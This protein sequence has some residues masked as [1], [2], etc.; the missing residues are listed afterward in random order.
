[1]AVLLLCA[2]DPLANQTPRMAFQTCPDVAVPKEP[3]VVLLKLS[4]IALSTLEASI[5]SIGIN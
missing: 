4:M 3:D 1:V 5:P 2:A